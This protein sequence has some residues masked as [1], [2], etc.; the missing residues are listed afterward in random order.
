M[1]DWQIDHVG[2]AVPDLE[3]AI[4]AYRDIFGYELVSGPFDDPIQ[5]ARVCFMG[6]GSDKET[7]IEL[8]APL[9]EKSHVA[10]MVAKGIGAYHICYRVHNIEAELERVKSKKCLP[11]KGPDPAVAYGGRRVAWF[12]TPTRQLVELVEWESA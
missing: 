10:S 4:S 2:V 1:A 6:N 9:G 11:I 7:T 8:I 3:K 5:Q 12:F